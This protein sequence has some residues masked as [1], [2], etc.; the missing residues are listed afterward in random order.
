[1]IFE[2]KWRRLASRY[3]WDTHHRH[4][5]RRQHLY[6]RGGGHTQW[7]RCWWYVINSTH[8]NLKR[9]CRAT[10]IDSDEICMVANHHTQTQKRERKP[11]MRTNFGPSPTEP[12]PKRN[13]KE[14]FL[15][16]GAPHCKIY[17]ASVLFVHFQRRRRHKKNPKQILS[18][19]VLPG[20]GFK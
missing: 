2:I 17:F 16:L 9:D 19:A 10:T 4:R 13:H 20:V 11:K 6:R 7:H 1:M 12:P 8:L 5:R 15:L 18:F 3:E 14:S